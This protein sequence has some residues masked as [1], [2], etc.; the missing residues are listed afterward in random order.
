MT[1][2]DATVHVGAH[3]VEALD[4]AGHRLT[5]PR[6]AVAGLVAA[7]NGHFTAAE[8]VEDARRRRLDVGRA[9]IFRAL[10]LF[11]SLSLVEHVDLPGGEHAYVACDPV[12]HHH[13]ICTACG[14]SFDVSD[15]GLGEVLG[16]IGKRLGFT[17]TA[18]RLE[19]FGQCAG[20]AVSTAAAASARTA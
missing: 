12:H 4:R 7:R 5:E 10:D 13:A 17:V 11:T 19:I 15:L 20:C 2:E 18:H 16:A 1:S 14:R 6:R 3:L 8:L 9:T